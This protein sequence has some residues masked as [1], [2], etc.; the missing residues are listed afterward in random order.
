MNWDAIGAIG[1]V[2]GAAAVVLSL[3][4]VATQIRENTSWN[5]RQALEKIIDRVIDW[6]ARLNENPEILKVYL[7]GLEGFEK[8]SAEDKH[9][10]HY[11]L[12]ELFVASEAVLEHAKNRSIK[13]ETVDAINERM[14]YELR[15]SGSRAWWQ[16]MGRQHFARDFSAHVDQLSGLAP[17]GK[18]PEPDA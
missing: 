18:S 3:L 4:Y 15:G 7:E 12:F 16:T 13:V 2:V 10:Y 11:A 1:E 9:R 6:S 17:P 5:K 8:L 14:K